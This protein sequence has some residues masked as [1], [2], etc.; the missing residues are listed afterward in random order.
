MISTRA[1]AELP[2]KCGVYLLKDD[3]GRIVYIG[4]SKSIKKR[5][6]AHLRTKLAGKIASADYILTKGE[7]SA[8]ILEAGL[9]KK[10]KPRYNVSM[11]DDKQYPYV[12][13]TLNEDYPALKISRKTE[14]DGAEYFGPFRSAG[15]RQI[16]KIVSRVFGLRSCSSGVFKKRRQPCLNYYM[17]RCQAPCIGRIS[18]Q[19][20]AARASQAKKFLSSG[21]E[22]FAE[23]I[24]KRMEEASLKKKFELA[25]DLRDKL[26]LIERSIDVPFGASRPPR[27]N[28]AA[29]RDL[30]DKL[31]LAELP[32]RIE[33]FDISNTGS[34][35]TVGGMAV[36]ENGAPK[37]E[38]YRRF[39]ISA[40]KMPNDTAAIYETV[41][42]RYSG[43]LK[44]RLPFPD[45]VVIDG[46]AGQLAS[47]QKALKDANV[48]RVSLIS[49]AKKKEEI[50]TLQGPAPLVLPLDSKALLLLRAL[51]DE[52]H[53]FAVSYHRK[54]RA[55]ALMLDD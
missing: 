48:E 47:A 40:A 9:I 22:K 13:F 33:A 5:V 44:D 31:G 20:Y 19:K 43:S 32:V 4:K 16:I 36:F 1:I 38:H 54:R 55:K 18:K 3:S 51:R 8:L 41:F 25:A 24:R 45:L 7:L 14:P 6:T 2:D 10:H 23:E 30:K 34:S 28:D 15:A 26:Y 42:R 21:P 17:K 12:K 11:R 37:K 46:G 49:I 50:Y 53:R 52:V 39:K 27:R 29:L 35:E